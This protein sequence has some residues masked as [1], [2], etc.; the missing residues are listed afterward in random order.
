MFQ[1]RKYKIL[2]ELN[3][4]ADHSTA[5]L[6]YLYDEQNPCIICRSDSDKKR[7]DFAQYRNQFEAYM[8][9]L[10]S[11]GFLVHTCND[12]YF[13]LTSLG[14]H[15]KKY[16]LQELSKFVIRSIL[17]PIIVG[18]ISSCITAYVMPML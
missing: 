2:K 5:E 17:V 12:Y 8:D 9:E 4:L 18:V 1:I 3:K 6:C 14:L 13:R 16:F 10:F 11:N 7:H 15:Y